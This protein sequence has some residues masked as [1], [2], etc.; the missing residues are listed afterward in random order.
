MLA[1]LK[2][3]WHHDFPDEPV[4]MLSE[5]RDGWEVR[6]VEKFRDGRAQCAGP[7]GTSGDT[8][9]SETSLPTPDEI[10]RDPQFTVEP[11]DADEFE[12]EWDATQRA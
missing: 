11:T 5:V 9:L 8:V 3:I 6:K 10:A 1:Y 2:V 7:S 4:V 12:A